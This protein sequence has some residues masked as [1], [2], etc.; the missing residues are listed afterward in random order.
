MR[1]SNEILSN[2]TWPMLGNIVEDARFC[3]VNLAGKVYSGFI[4]LCE[5]TFTYMWVQCMANK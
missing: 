3:K 2:E 4:T 5:L 1:F